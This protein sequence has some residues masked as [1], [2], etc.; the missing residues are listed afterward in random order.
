MAYTFYPNSQL[1]FVIPPVVN[2]R[3]HGERPRTPRA[4]L[5]ETLRFI[6]RET[7]YGILS[8]DS[9]IMPIDEIETNGVVSRKSIQEPRVLSHCGLTKVIMERQDSRPLTQDPDKKWQQERDYTEEL[10]AIGEYLE[11]Q[12]EAER[13]RAGGAAMLRRSVVNNSGF[14]FDNNEN[15]VPA[16]LSYTDAF[17]IVGYLPG[18]SRGR[19]GLTNIFIP[20]PTLH[21]ERVEFTLLNPLVALEPVVA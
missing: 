12:V 3:Y 7:P 16:S 2:D 14:M 20:E 17:E 13:K 1:R 21:V 6:E 4:M 11:G 9:A 10:T 18:I 15:P 5:A 19:D 8:V